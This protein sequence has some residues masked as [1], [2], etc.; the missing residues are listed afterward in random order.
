MDPRQASRSFAKNQGLS[1]ARDQ[2]PGADRGNSFVARR[3]Q[4]EKRK[5]AA[6]AAARAAAAFGRHPPEHREH[7]LAFV[8]AMARD[9]VRLELAGQ[10]ADVTRSPPSTKA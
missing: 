8:R 9:A 6:M 3:G 7:L 4:Q 5:G 2:T 1:T 10:A